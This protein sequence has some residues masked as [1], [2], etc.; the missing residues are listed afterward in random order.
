[1]SIGPELVVPMEPSFERPTDGRPLG[2]DDRVHRR[3]A[4]VRILA[5]NMGRL[6]VPENPLEGCAEPQ[7]PCA[8][9]AVAGV[10]LEIDPSDAPDLEG[11]GEQ[12]KLRLAVDP[13][14]SGRGGQPG[15]TDLDRVGSPV[16]R[17]CTEVEEAGDTDYPVVA[18]R[19]LGERDSLATGASSKQSVEVAHHRG[20]SVRHA[21][22]TVGRA[23]LSGRRDEPVHVCLGELLKSNESAS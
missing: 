20:A 2:A 8:G 15:S 22:I 19:D 7:D 17:S 16:A 1:M 14:T 21:R 23:I 5:R 12:E 9:S 4:K 6:P 18:Q 10:G 3:I 13:G 11:V